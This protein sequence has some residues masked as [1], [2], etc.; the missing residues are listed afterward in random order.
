[1][2]PG[3]FVEVVFSPSEKASL[4][5]LSDS[6]KELLQ[7][8]DAAKLVDKGDIY[9]TISVVVIEN[10]KKVIK[11]ITLLNDLLPRIVEPASQFWEDLVAIFS[12]LPE[13]IVSEGKRFLLYTQPVKGN[14]WDHV[15]YLHLDT[16]SGKF[17]ILQEYGAPTMYTAKRGMYKKLQDLNYV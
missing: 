3:D 13:G 8:I 7:E 1:M 11:L 12:V 17:E 10:G 6:D 4:R 5:K 16:S 2:K 9:S 15:K 14:G